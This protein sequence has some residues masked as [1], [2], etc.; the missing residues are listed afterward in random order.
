MTQKWKGWTLKPREEVYDNQCWLQ[1]NLALTIT[2]NNEIMKFDFRA[3]KK[4]KIVEQLNK[5]GT[6]FFYPLQ[7]I[8]CVEGF[9][10]VG[11]NAGQVYKLDQQLK[12][13]GKTKG[14]STGT[15]LSIASGM[16]K[17]FSCGMDRRLMVHDFNSLNL[18][19]KKYLWQ[20]LTK[21][22]VVE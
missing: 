1:E 9:V 13:L 20:K 17:V 3:G 6:T 21:V 19:D 5:P 15:V 11:D 18:V 2:A 12:V 7:S 14:R 8:F 22:I 10:L 16:G 4:P